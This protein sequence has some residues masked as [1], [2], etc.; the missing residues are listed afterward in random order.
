[1]A[2]I[3]PYALQISGRSQRLKETL[4]RVPITVHRRIIYGLVPV[5]LLI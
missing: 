3:N 4:M 2:G 5:W 1:M